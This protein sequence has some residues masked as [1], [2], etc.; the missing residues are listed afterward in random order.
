MAVRSGET[1]HS[2]RGALLSQQHCPERKVSRGVTDPTCFQLLRRV[3]EQA[4]QQRVTQA[5]HSPRDH[6]P[7]LSL[8]E[9]SILLLFY[10]WSNTIS[11]IQRLTSGGRQKTKFQ[12]TM[13][14]YLSPSPCPVHT[15]LSILPPPQTPSSSVLLPTS[16]STILTSHMAWSCL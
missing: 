5:I 9:S 4:A 1:S 14:C 2:G 7:H 12:R 8:L 15:P 11:A 13:P 16:L 6:H 3:N 10:S